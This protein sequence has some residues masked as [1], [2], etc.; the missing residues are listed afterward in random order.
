MKTPELNKALLDARGKFPAIERDRTVDFVTK[1]GQRVHY[2]HATLTRIYEQLVP[3]LCQHGLVWTAIPQGDRLVGTLRHISGEFLEGWLPIGGETKQD[4]GGAITY[5]TRY[6]FASMLGVAAEADSDGAVQSKQV[7]VPSA[8]MQAQSNS[9]VQTSGGLA[10]LHRLEPLG[11]VISG[12]KIK[13]ICDLDGQDVEVLLFPGAPL[14]YVATA[15]CIDHGQAESWANRIFSGGNPVNVAGAPFGLDLK[16]VNKNGKTYFNIDT[17]REDYFNM[18]QPLIQTAL[19]QKYTMKS[20]QDWVQAIGVNDPANF[21]GTIEEATALLK[22][23]VEE[24][25]NSHGEG[26]PW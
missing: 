10:K 19:G 20:P 4:E 24:R 7:S 18:A 2:S 1:K 25:A 26:I 12:A 5:S 8:G 17:N 11:Q 16:T 22:S 9:V 21:K 23:F 13:A 3:I 6:L 15:F 14:D